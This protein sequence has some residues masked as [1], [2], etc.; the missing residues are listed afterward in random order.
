VFFEL[1]LEALSNKPLSYEINS[2]Y[3]YSKFVNEIFLTKP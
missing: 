3:K 2:V 1:F